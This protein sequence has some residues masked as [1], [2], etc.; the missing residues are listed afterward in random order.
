M[1]GGSPEGMKSRVPLERYLDPTGAR[2]YSLVAEVPYAPVDLDLGRLARGEWNAATDRFR[3]WFMPRTGRTGDEPLCHVMIRKFDQQGE[4]ILYAH[5]VPNLAMTADD[6][7]KVPE[8]TV[9]ILSNDD[10]RAKSSLGLFIGIPPTFHQRDEIR[11][12]EKRWRSDPNAVLRFAAN[13]HSSV[14]TAAGP[15]PGKVVRLEFQPPPELLGEL[16]RGMGRWW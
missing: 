9:G 12:F 14:G 2:V 7:G 13:V 11:I 5:V 1:Y 3:I 16:K 15:D 4:V 6:E 10:V 8:F